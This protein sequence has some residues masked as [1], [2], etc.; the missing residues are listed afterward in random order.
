MRKT[1]LDFILDQLPTRPKYSVDL[2]CGRFP[3]NPLGAT[4]LYGIDIGST[5]P[6]LESADL[7]YKRCIPGRELPFNSD[8][9]EVVTAY[10]FIEH[11]PRFDRNSSGEAINPFIE[12]MNEIYRIL[13]PGGLF[14]AVTP[15]YPSSAAFTDPTHVNFITPE[16]HNYFSGPCHARELS[17]GYVGNF[18]AVVTKW[19]G[20]DHPVWLRQQSTLIKRK[21]FLKTIGRKLGLRKKVSRVINFRTRKSKGANG[22]MYYLWVLQKLEIQ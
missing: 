8:E 11:I 22:E 14:I 7:I 5:S 16:T 15:C 19:I 6:F 20:I 1:D 3:R 2:G 13:A 21:G 10:D 9:V 18:R 4:K 12:I 17:Y